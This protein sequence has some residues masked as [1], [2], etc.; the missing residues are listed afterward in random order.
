MERPSAIKRAAALERT[1]SVI[2]A[3]EVRDRIRD[4]YYTDIWPIK[5]DSYHETKDFLTGV[6]NILMDFVKKSNDRS[7]KIVDFRQPNELWQEYDFAIPD[8]PQSVD[9]LLVDC[10]EALRHQV[11]TGHPHYFNQISC[12]LDIV[13]MAGEWLTATANTNMFTYEI[14]PIFILMEHVVLKK[15]R[16]VIGFTEGDSILA[17]GGAISNLYAVLVARHKMFPEYKTK[18]LRGLPQLVLFTSEHSHYSTKGGGVVS[19]LGT[20]NVVEVPCDERGR[21]IPSELERLVKERFDKGDRPY[22][23]NCTTGTTVVGAFDPIN[24]IADVCDKYDLWLHI[25]AAWGGGCLMSKTHRSKFDGVHRAKSLTWNPHKLLGSI[26]QCSTVHFKENGLLLGCNAMCA[27]YLFQQDK[28]YDVSY[29]TGD[30]VIQCGR[31]ND[32]FKYWL[33]WRSRGMI[34][35]EKHVDHLFDMSNYL[36]AKLKAEPDKFHVLFPEPELVNVCFWYIPERLRNVPHSKEKE[37]ELG[38]VT[39]QLKAR[40][41]DAGTLMISYQP[42]GDIPNFFRNIVS[43]AGVQEKDMDFIVTELDRLGHDL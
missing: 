24:P 17:P 32:I 12:G 10:Y 23:V 40:M 18:G 26:L 7:E 31:H 36:L 43:N 33:M 14:A 16:E 4:L 25:D 34:G 2:Q 38:K 20:D 21:M 30:K 42:L 35:Y 6:F 9:Q 13:S 11:K 3:E 8:E 41:M 28:H 27:D 39:A 37:H 15:M 29:D 22:F 1:Q 19:G 5:E